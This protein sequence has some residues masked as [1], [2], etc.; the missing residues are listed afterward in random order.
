M[1][2]CSVTP[3][4]GSS[5]DPQPKALGTRSSAPSGSENRWLISLS[6]PYAEVPCLGL[7]PPPTS[8]SPPHPSR[9][10]KGA[11]TLKFTCIQSSHRPWQSPCDSSIQISLSQRLPNWAT[12][13]PPFTVANAATHS[14]GSNFKIPY[15]FISLT[16]SW[17]ESVR[18][19]DSNAL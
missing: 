14:K 19:G 12:P 18:C 1:P 4:V 7:T 16:P 9:P 6:W 10:F 15:N 2:R 5:Q 17:L 8:Q 13:H 3:V 11:D